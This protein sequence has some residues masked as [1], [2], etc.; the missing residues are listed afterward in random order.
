MILLTDFVFTRDWSYIVYL[1]TPY[2][3][4]DSKPLTKNWV[5]RQAL[6]YKTLPTRM[7][8]SDFFS[9]KPVLVATGYMLETLETFLKIKYW[10]FLP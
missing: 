2:D 8:N 4:K 9:R 7:N 10:S 3:P 5:K 6:G 1:L